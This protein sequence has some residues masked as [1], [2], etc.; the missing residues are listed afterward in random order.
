MQQRPL[1]PLVIKSVPTGRYLPGGGSQRGSHQEVGFTWGGSPIGLT[2]RG[3]FHL[4]RVM[5]SHQVVFTWG[6]LPVGLAL[7]VGFTWGG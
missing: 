6:G 5:V 7:E 1:Q 4:G 3:G 2:P